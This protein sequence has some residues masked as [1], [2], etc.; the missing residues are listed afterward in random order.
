MF[1]QILNSLES[2]LEREIILVTGGTGLVGSALLTQLVT[3]SKAHIRAIYRSQHPDISHVEWVKSDILD[4]TSLLDVMEGVDKIY[5]CAAAVDFQSGSAALLRKTNVEGT[6]NV[7]NAALLSNVSRLL[8]VSSVAA[9]GGTENSLIDEHFQWN[10]K[11]KH[12]LY[13][14]SKFAAEMEVWRGQAEGLDTVIVNPSIILGAGDWTKG[15]TEIF[16]TVY[17]QFPWYSEGVHG[18][19]DVQDVVIAMLLLMENT[20]ISGERF[21]LNADN[22]TYKFLFDLIADSFHVP[23]P[24]KKVTPFLA[25]IVWRMKKIKGILTGKPPMLTKETAHTALAKISYDNRKI[26]Q[27]LPTFTFHSLAETVQLICKELAQKYDLK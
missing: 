5:H 10:E 6:A 20:A 12:S 19:V 21:I 11:E 15:S 23:R 17:T 24:A 7:V 22:V 26:K 8:F 14:E 4:I 9:I 3:V 2:G 16:R 18:F 13:A 25:A 1:A 27:F